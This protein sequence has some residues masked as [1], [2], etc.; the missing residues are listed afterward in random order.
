[1]EEW[2]GGGMNAPIEL[3]MGMEKLE[4]DFSLK[5]PNEEILKLCGMVDHAGAALR[6]R[7]ALEA[8]DASATV[9]P[10][11]VV[12]RGRWRE[13]DSGS[14]KPGDEA[15]MKVSVACSYYRYTSGGSVLVEI[16]VPNMVEKVGGRDRLAAIRNAIGG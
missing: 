8:D 14:W 10:V 13:I 4:C 9:T 5:E 6:F 2:R 12:V 7:G 3:D 16:D 15:L 11:E 1:M